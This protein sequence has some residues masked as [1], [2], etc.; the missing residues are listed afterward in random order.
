MLGIKVNA[1]VPMLRAMIDLWQLL[2]Y[3]A[4]ATFVIL[5]QF[6]L[7]RAME[8]LFIDSRCN[9][10]GQGRLSAQEVL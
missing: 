1:N 8:R 9:L 6:I 3:P 7:V 4:V 5:R 10:Q 2:C